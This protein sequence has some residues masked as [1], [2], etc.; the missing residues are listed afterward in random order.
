M[1]KLPLKSDSIAAEER[2]QII[3]GLFREAEYRGYGSSPAARV[4][5]L[6]KLATIY[7]LDAPIKAE[8]TVTSAV[9][10]NQKFDFSKLSKLELKLVRELLESRI[11]A[12]M[13]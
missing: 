11:A 4:T 8:T 6:S 9:D 5:A 10:P 12:D 2:T 7:G 3:E 13:V 1:K